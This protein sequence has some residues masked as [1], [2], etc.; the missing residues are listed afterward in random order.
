MD[1]DS[2]NAQNGGTQYNADTLETRDE[3]D[4][5]KEEQGGGENV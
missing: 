3:E 4:W 1:K 2:A 5:S